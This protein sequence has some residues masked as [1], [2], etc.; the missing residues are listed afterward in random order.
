MRRAAAVKLDPRFVGTDRS[1][2]LQDYRTS[3][4]QLSSTPK[5]VG[6]TIFINFSS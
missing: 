2:R 1:L 4:T 6:A 3:V 5:G